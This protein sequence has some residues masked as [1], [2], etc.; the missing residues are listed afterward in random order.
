MIA[1]NNMMTNFIIIIIIMLKYLK[2]SKNIMEIIYK[3]IFINNEFVKG[4][5]DS[6]IPIIDPTNE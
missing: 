1:I 2:N 6:Q 3:D 4:S 5:N